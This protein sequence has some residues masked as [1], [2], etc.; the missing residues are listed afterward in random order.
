MQ[1]ISAGPP[2]SSSVC[3]SSS[4]CA[5]VWFWLTPLFSHVLL[6]PSIDR[7]L[8]G[9]QPPHDLVVLCVSMS[10]FSS[11]CVAFS[12]IKPRERDFLKTLRLVSG[13][14]ACAVEQ[15]GDTMDDDDKGVRVVCAP[16]STLFPYET[17]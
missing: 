4:L 11:S 17:D 5:A 10:F 8:S 12:V 13:T 3:L 16:P 1:R 6:S 14:E 2:L 15:H 7:Y 9:V